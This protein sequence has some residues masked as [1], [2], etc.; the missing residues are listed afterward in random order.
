MRYPLNFTNFQ[1]SF[2][3]QHHQATA[4]VITLLKHLSESVVEK[5]S[6]LT[7]LH[8][9][10]EQVE[11]KVTRDECSMF[12]VEHI[13]SLSLIHFKLYINGRLVIRLCTIEHFSLALFPYFTTAIYTYFCCPFSMLHFCA[14]FMLNHFHVVLF[15]AV[16]FSC[17]TFFIFHC[18]RVVLFPCCTFFILHNFHFVFFHVAL[19]LCIA[20][21]HVALLYIGTF[22]YCI[23][24]FVL[25]FFFCCTLFILQRCSRGVA[26]TTTNI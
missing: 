3:T 14:F 23:A 11:K 24:L 26:R 25:H 5:T 15:C 12:F 6:I 1:S 4:S 17:C 22:S 13:S 10:I 7:I 8:F 2:F 18:F 9:K 19:F 16:I 21:F 20:L